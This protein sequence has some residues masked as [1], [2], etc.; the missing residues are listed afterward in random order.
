MQMATI[1]ASAG[2]QLRIAL[3]AEVDPS[4]GL[5]HSVATSSTAAPLDAVQVRMDAVLRNSMAC[6]G[7]AFA[8]DDVE[9][10]R[11]LSQEGMPADRTVCGVPIIPISMLDTKEKKEAYATRIY[12][13]YRSACFMQP[14]WPHTFAALFPHTVHAPRPRRPLPLLTSLQWRWCVKDFYLRA[15]SY[16]ASCQPS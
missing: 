15:S 6:L 10:A 2:P 1:P 5:V 3:V 9:R 11:I 13:A 12:R 14:L 7:P 8:A 16:S 4:G